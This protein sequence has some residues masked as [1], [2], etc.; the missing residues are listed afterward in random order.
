VLHDRVRI[1]ADCHVR[2]SVLAE[3]V[4]VG[5]RARIDSGA[6]V[7]AGATI[8]EG[9][10]VAAAA[11]VA[12]AVSLHT[13][14]LRAVVRGPAPSGLTGAMIADSLALPLA[15]EMRA[16]PGLAGALERGE[17]PARRG[18]GPLARLCA[19]LLDT[20]PAPGRAAAA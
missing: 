12:A 9:A 8:G 13:A 20:M 5:D 6:L 10:V 7:G 11:R 3:R 15:G 14:D 2:D 18:K 16:E 1:G 17:P 19:G 4:Q